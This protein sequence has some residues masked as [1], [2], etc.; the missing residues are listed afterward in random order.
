MRK[1]SSRERYYMLLLENLGD[2]GKDVLLKLYNKIWEEGSS[3]K[4]GRNLF[5]YQL[6]S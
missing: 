5:L 2:S 4:S 1:V 6:G 3:L